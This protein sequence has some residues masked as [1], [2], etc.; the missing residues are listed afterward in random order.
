MPKR[1]CY[2][3]YRIEFR[4]STGEVKKAYSSFFWNGLGVGFGVMGFG[5]MGDGVMGDG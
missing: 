2:I 1:K 3:G 5:V 4:D